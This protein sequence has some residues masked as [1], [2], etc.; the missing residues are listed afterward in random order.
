MLFRW[1]SWILNL[2]SWKIEITPAA[3][4]QIRKLDPGSARRIRD[5]LRIRI[6]GLDD[7]RQVGKPLRGLSPGSFWR[8]RAGDYRILCELREAELVVLIVKIGHRREV[9][10]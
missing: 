10:R 4:R 1:T 7:P 6:A 5:Y 3:A 8:Y 2:E 9:F